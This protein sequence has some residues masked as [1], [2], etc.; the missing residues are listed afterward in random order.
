MALVSRL[1]Q[2]RLDVPHEPGEYFMVRTLGW[3][4]LEECRQARARSA[5]V[6]A[7]EVGP[8]LLDA[9]S[10]LEDVED[11]DP[12]LKQRLAEAEAR[13]AKERDDSRSQFDKDLLLSRSVEGWSYEEKFT[14]QG[15]LSLDECTAEWLFGAIADLYADTE[16]EQD[17]GNASTPS[18]SSSTETETK[19]LAPTSGT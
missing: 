9:F 10:K 1:P 4:E 19:A 15:L 17:R 18:T 16:T 12:G 14:K 3:R 11:A 8:E 7:R 6:A 13:R 2:K 5:V